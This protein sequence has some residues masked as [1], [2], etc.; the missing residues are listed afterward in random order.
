MAHTKDFSA[1]P[2]DA[3]A[4]RRVSDLSSPS[5]DE[6]CRLM[7]EFMNIRHPALREAVIELVTRLSISGEKLQ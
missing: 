7:R 6:G 5:R 2:P 1:V 4:V 3:P